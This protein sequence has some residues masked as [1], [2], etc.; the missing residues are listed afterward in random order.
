MHEASLY[1]DNAFLTLTYSPEWLPPFGSLD[2]RAFP[3][4]MKRLRKSIEPRKVRYLHAGEYG[5]RFGRPH[6]HAVLF[7]YDFPDKA[8]WSER[9]GFPVWRSSA[10]AELWPFGQAELGTV[11]FE[12][13]AY[14]AR[15]VCKKVTGLAA[16]PHY[17][18]M[19]EDGVLH[20]REPEYMT[21]SRRPGIG[22]PW[23]DRYGAECYSSGAGGVLVRGQLMRPPRYYDTLEEERDPAQ[24]ERV[25]HERQ[26][27]TSWADRTLERLEVREKCAKAKQSLKPRR[28]DNA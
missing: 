3:L 28:L 11:T 24:L 5:S 26:L 25:Q 20:D 22:R 8:Q 2:R 19:D 9:N 27:G 7:G 13:I 1:Q 23:F 12:S 10:L 6:Y 21:M 15:Y 14:V 17:E 16:K 18:V 4:F